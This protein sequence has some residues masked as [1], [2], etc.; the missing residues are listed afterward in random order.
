M[1]CTCTLK[2]SRRGDGKF[3]RAICAD[4][5]IAEYFPQYPTL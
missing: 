3:G 4:Q 2:R 5:T 1:L